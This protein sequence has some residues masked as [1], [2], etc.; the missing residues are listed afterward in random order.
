MT[1]AMT[2]ERAYI[3]AIPGTSPKTFLPYP[4]LIFPDGEL[5]QS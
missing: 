2:R 5:E 3:P 4:S 1:V